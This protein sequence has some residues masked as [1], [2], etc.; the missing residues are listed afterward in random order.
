MQIKTSVCD[1]LHNSLENM[2]CVIDR[3]GLNGDLGYSWYNTIT[4]GTS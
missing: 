2:G 4:G 3:H 1:I